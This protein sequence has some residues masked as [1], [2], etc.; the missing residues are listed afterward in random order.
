MVRSPVT[1]M[2]VEPY[3]SVPSLSMVAKDVPA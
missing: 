2:T 3:C 1:F